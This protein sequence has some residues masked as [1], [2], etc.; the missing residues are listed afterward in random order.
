MK[1]TQILIEDR[2]YRALISMARRTGKGLSQ[3]VREAVDRMIGS[4]VETKPRRRLEDICGKWSDPE[5]LPASE[6]DR[7]IYDE[8]LP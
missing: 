8:E 5:G 3:L 6:H 4:T 1:R 7:I 2:Q